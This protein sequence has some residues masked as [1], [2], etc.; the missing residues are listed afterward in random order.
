MQRLT[1]LG[2]PPT[3]MPSP[4]ATVFHVTRMY[5]ST[6]PLPYLLSNMEILRNIIKGLVEGFCEAESGALRNN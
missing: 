3:P 4:G 2:A 5:C 1:T 6:Y